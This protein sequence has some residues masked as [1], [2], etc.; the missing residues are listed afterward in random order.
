MEKEKLKDRLKE[1]SLEQLTKWEQEC[2]GEGR[3]RHSIK[4]LLTL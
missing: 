4:W 2:H 1:V 3:W